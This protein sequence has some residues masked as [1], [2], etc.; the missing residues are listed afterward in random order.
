M[1]L[2][3]SIIVPTCN[4]QLLKQCI[5]SIVK[6]TDFRL[7]VAEV[8]ISCNGAPVETKEYIDSLGP[9]FKYI[10]NDNK[11][12]VCSA[13]N[14]AVKISSGK[15]IVKMDD[16]C[17][18][19]PWASNS[20]W[21]LRLLK[22]FEECRLVGQTGSVVHKHHN[23]NG[24][25]EYKKDYCSAIGFLTM[26][27]KKIWDQLNGLDEIFNPGI[28]EDT[29]FS[30]KVQD[31]GYQIVQ[32]ASTANYD[33]K[34]FV[35]DFPLIHNSHTSYSYNIQELINKNRQILKERYS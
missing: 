19:L 16:D 14:N 8:I 25:L 30:F 13:M 24:T 15:Y 23:T 20:E 34:I 1:H 9:H 22:P 21:I 33:G 11:I 2:D 35:N 12:G 31:L 27:T 10:W 5:S 26:T 3:F 4:L 7:T 29:D 18:L 32:A 28:G 17:T 6:Y